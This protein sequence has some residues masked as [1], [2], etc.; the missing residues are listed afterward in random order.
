MSRSKDQGA[1]VRHYKHTT[2]VQSL[3]LATGSV[4]SH[5]QTFLCHEELTT[6]CLFRSE[7]TGGR[8]GVGK[9]ASVG[10]SSSQNLL[11]QPL[12]GH[13]LRYL[14][15]TLHT[16]GRPLGPSYNSIIQIA[17]RHK[18]CPRTNKKKRLLAVCNSEYICAQKYCSQLINSIIYLEK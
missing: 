17:W 14:T 3:C 18:T 8:V 16:R 10:T 2:E 13:L 15:R 6:G 1:I 7:A 9:A 12:G 5:S 4:G 11:S